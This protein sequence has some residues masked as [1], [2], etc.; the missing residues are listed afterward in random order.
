MT[1]DNTIVLSTDDLLEMFGPFVYPDNEYLTI[2]IS[3]ESLNSLRKWKQ[4]GI[5]INFDEFI[6]LVD[7]GLL[8]ADF[9]DETKQENWW[10]DMKTG[11]YFG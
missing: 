7:V 5:D 3:M 1:S 4:K 10:D 2:S 11:R 6:L 8:D 9:A